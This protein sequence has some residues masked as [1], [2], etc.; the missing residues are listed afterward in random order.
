MKAAVDR[1]VKESD[2]QVHG[3]ICDWITL[4]D[5]VQ[6]HNDHVSR[7]HPESCQ[8]LLQ[9]SAFQE[10]RQTPKQ[11]LCCYGIPGAGKTILSSIVIEQLVFQFHKSN[12]DVGIAY[13][14]CSSQRGHE[15]RFGDLLASLLR[16]LI[17]KQPSTPDMVKLLYQEHQPKG[18]RPSINQLSETLQSVLASYSRAFVVIDALDECSTLDGCQTRFI[19]SLLALQAGSRANLFL[20]S[21]SSSPD[22]AAKLAGIPEIQV[23]ADPEDVKSYLAE[24]MYRLPG[25]VNRDPLLQE[26]IQSGIVKAVDG[27]SVTYLFQGQDKITELTPS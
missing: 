17:E 25:F 19:D 4:V 7:Q 24:Q 21:R 27:M 13:I 9:S 23:R 26:E 1:L 22:I 8:W 5:N 12:N 14:Y 18:S 11:T 10:W 2:G 3:A 15:Q 16:Q 6:Y 20:T